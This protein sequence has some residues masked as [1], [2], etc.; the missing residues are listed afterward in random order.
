M[1][2]APILESLSALADPIRT[3]LLRTLETQELTV[4]ELCTVVQLPQ[5][6]VSR[7]LKVLADG[8]WVRIRRDGARRL[9]S[10]AADDLEPHAHELWRVTREHIATT[11]A[12]GEDA[13]RLRGILAQRSTRSREFFAGAAAEWD[14][15][16]VELFGQRMLSLSLLGLLGNDWTVADLGCGT[17]PVTAALAPFVGRVIAIDGSPEML[18]AARSRLAEFPNVDLRHADLESVPIDD[19]EADAAT[20]ILVLHHLPDPARVLEEV[21]RILRPG[22]K[23][24]VLDMLPHDRDEYRQRMGHVWMGFSAEELKRRLDS[25]GLRL[26]S[27]RPLPPDPDALGPGLFAATAVK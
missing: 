8:A 11:R 7:H 18:A 24:L 2:R 27:F 20:L 22:G 25:V 23:L 9:Y 3:R 6:T 1:E 16:R 13:R 4:S 5:S 15:L 26:E 10:L 17:G 19:S 21:A 12:A 14:R